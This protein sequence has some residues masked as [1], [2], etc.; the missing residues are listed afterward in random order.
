M[1]IPMPFAAASATASP[2]AATED[3]VAIHPVAG[4]LVVIV[5]DGAGGISGGGRAADLA[6][7]LLAERIGDPHFDPFSADAWAHALVEADGELERDCAGGETTCVVVALANDGRLVGVSSGDSRAIIV[8]LGAGIDDLTAQQK[9]KLRLGS[10]RAFPVVFARDALNGTLV[11][12]TDGLFNYTELDDIAEALGAG[13]DDVAAIARGLVERVRLPRGTFMDDV[14]V[15]V[16][17]GPAHP[18]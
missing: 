10:G 17:H 4:G 11:V 8:S 14:A 1:L 12:A 16:V 5:A 6:L 2:R 3:R 9:P 18:S 13:G 7:A 15:V